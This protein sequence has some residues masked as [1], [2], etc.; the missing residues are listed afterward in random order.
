MTLN[1]A[2]MDV[3]TDNI[4]IKVLLLNRL[5]YEFW[6]NKWGL[7][8]TICEWLITVIILTILWCE[9]Y[10]YWIL[11]LRLLYSILFYSDWSDLEDFAALDFYFNHYFLFKTQ[12]KRE[13]LEE[14][15][16]AVRARSNVV[17]LN[18]WIVYH[19]TLLSVDF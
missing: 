14:L 4:I 10:R 5:Y 7:I 19:L 9:L 18:E 13:K 2:Q 6:V 15:I 16:V 1:I 8:L 11:Y 17:L 3:W 12:I